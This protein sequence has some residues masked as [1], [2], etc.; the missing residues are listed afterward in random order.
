MA[1]NVRAAVCNHHIV[2]NITHHSKAFAAFV[3]A[4][5]MILAPNV[6]A[7]PGPRQV[8]TPVKTMKQA[9]ALK[10]GTQIAISCGNCGGISTLTVDDDRSFMKGVTCPSCKHVFR[11]MPGGGG[12]SADQFTL[13][14]KYGQLAH[15][16]SRGKL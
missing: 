4:A 9:Q 8:F 14:D 6:Q 5:A 2:M 1:E 3:G 11:I 7:G 16:A 15:L 13:V 12:R 10:P